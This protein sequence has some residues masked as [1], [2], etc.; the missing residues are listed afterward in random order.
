[1]GAFTETPTR[2]AELKKY[3]VIGIG[4]GGIYVVVQH[5]MFLRDSAGKL[6]GQ[7]S[8]NYSRP[9]G[10]FKSIVFNNDDNIIVY[11]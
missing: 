5:V 4:E 1:M 3:D 10:L 9:R 6:T 11:S 2:A 8:V 7:V